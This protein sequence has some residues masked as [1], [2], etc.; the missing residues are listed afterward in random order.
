M[1]EA[2]GRGG[3]ASGGGGGRGMC[4]QSTASHCGI[5]VVESLIGPVPGWPRNY[6]NLLNLLFKT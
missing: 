3:A 5:L 1:M 6:F 2:K 4:N